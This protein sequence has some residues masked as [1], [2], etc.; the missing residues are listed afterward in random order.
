MLVDSLCFVD[1]LVIS[2]CRPTCI[3]RLK[4]KV[5]QIKVHGR[6][7][8]KVTISAVAASQER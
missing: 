3:G 7:M 2:T 5:I 8:K 6:T 1:V 4:T